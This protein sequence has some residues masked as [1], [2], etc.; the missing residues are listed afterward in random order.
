M[1]ASVCACVYF[2]THQLNS[3]NAQ[4]QE[5]RHYV[6][7]RDTLTPNTNEQTHK[8]VQRHTR[9]HTHTHTHVHART[10]RHLH[11]ITCLSIVLSVCLSKHR[12]CIPCPYTLATLLTYINLEHIQNVAVRA[13]NGENMLLI[14]DN[15]LQFVGLFL[16]NKHCVV[17]QS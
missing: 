8:Q 15:M 13:H 10:P 2:A 3:N 1:Y 12:K 14:C 16:S 11:T 4:K 9:S 17:P 7:H 6:T 5:F